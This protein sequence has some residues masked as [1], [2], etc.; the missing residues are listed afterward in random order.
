MEDNP[1]IEEIILEKNK[2]DANFDKASDRFYR[3]TIVEVW[4]IVGLPIITQITF[5][6][7]SAG[8]YG[9]AA[10]SAIATVITAENILENYRGYR[11]SVVV[12][13]FENQRYSN[14][15]KK[16]RYFLENQEIEN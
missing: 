2:S 6:F 14:N 5:S 12:M 3:S 9:L 4:N 1:T 13:E 7:Y 10:L 8:Y 11:D 16:L 15:N